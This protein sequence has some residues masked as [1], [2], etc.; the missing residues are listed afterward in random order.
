MLP[1]LVS[2]GCRET[3]G[4]INASADFKVSNEKN[5]NKNKTKHNKAKQNKK[6]LGPMGH[7]LP[8][9]QPK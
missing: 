2:V 6:M 1:P 8:A 7:F 4:L 3:K 9:K 5:K